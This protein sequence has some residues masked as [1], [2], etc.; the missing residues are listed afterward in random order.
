MRWY[1]KLEG[2]AKKVK[3][4][5]PDVGRVWL[6]II[7]WRKGTGVELFVLVFTTEGIG[8]QGGN[9]GI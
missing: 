9:Q 3:V 8:V 4:Y 5:L 6:M 7:W 2:Y 1:P